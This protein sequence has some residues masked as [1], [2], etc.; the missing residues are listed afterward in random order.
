M[1]SLT[2]LLALLTSENKY[3]FSTTFWK[4]AIGSSFC[5]FLQVIERLNLLTEALVV[6]RYFYRKAI[7]WLLQVLAGEDLATFTVTNDCTD[8]VPL[9]QDASSEAVLLYNL[10]LFFL[11]S[12]HLVWTSFYF[13]WL[14]SIFFDYEIWWLYLK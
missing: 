10:H 4:V 8:L 2:L 11:Q 6:L 13:L 7:L 9:M 5:L 3:A 14:N 12:F 1:I